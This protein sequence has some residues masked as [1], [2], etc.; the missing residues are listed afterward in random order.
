MDEITLT[1]LGSAETIPRDRHLTA[2]HV[3]VHGDKYLIEAPEGVQ[4]QL[5][6]RGLGL[7]IDTIFI[8]SFKKRSVLGLPGLLNTMSFYATR[9]EPLTIYC[10]PGGINRVRNIVDWFDDIDFTVNVKELI[11]GKFTHSTEHYQ[12]KTIP[13]SLYSSYGLIFTEESPRGTFNREK[14]ESLGVPVGPDF[15][16]LCNGESVTTPDGTTV[17]PH[18]VLGAAPD[19]ITIVYSGRTEPTTEVKDVATNANILIHDAGTLE[20]LPSIPDH[21]TIEQAVTL[22]NDAQP[23]VLFLNHISSRIGYDD[24]RLLSTARTHQQGEY[25]IQV[26]TAGTEITVTHERT[27]ISHRETR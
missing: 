17:H 16:K 24:D 25:D 22:A 21:S 15:T 14:A 3:N 18:D 6:R 23:G 4:R 27:T 9:E 20:H 10:P 19:P 2:T 7:T 26:Y 5:L 11:P 12:L 1:S 8:T 13:S